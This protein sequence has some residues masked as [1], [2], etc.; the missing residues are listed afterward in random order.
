MM[1]LKLASLAQGAS[2]VRPETVAML[3]V[4]LERELIPV[5][6]AQGSVGASGDLA[7]LAHMA[8]AMIGASEILVGGR[9]VPAAKALGEAGLEPLQLGP[10]EGLAL[11]NGTQFSTAYALAGLFEAEVLFQSALVTGRC[12]PRRPRVRIPRSMPESTSYAGIRASSKPPQAIRRLMADS[13]IRASHLTETRAFRIRIAS[14]VS[15]K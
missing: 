13:A 3:E 11:L 9:A 14:G 6:P 1:A 7:P 5:V 10:K 12:R 2:G 4:M 8:A 15:R